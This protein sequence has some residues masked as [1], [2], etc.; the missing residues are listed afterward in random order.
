MS[1]WRDP[2]RFIIQFLLSAGDLLAAMAQLIER[3]T[4]SVACDLDGPAHTG[5]RLKTIY[6]ALIRISGF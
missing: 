4:A 5:G 2:I 6:W 3:A 1:A